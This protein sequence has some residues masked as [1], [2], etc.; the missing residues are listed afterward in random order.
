MALNKNEKLDE[1]MMGGQ[2]SSQRQDD[3]QGSGASL[4][5]G[6]V[7][8][9]NIKGSSQQP[10]ENLESIAN[11]VQN[12]GP[13]ANATTHHFN[14]TLG[15]ETSKFYMSAGDTAEKLPAIGNQGSAAKLK[16]NVGG[17]YVGLMNKRNHQ[18]MASLDYNSGGAGLAVGQFNI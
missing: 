13:M 5:A 3:A 8:L 12:I 4:T 7:K 18:R 10:F 6:G 9:P 16:T 1:T 2:P 15:D 17:E 11:S 14:V